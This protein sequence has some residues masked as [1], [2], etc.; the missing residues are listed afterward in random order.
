MSGVP[1]PFNGAFLDRPITPAANQ[2]KIDVQHLSGVWGE[3]TIATTARDYFSTDFLQNGIAELI[4]AG[5]NPGNDTY[6]VA[7]HADVDRVRFTSDGEGPFNI[8]FFS[9]QAHKDLAALLGFRSDGTTVLEAADQDA[10]GHYYTEGDFSPEGVW[11]PMAGMAS[12]EPVREAP[13]VVVR[14]ADGGT[15]VDGWPVELDRITAEFAPVAPERVR[16]D[17]YARAES[18][19]QFWSNLRGGGVFN[20][21]DHRVVA[22][23]SGL[24]VTAFDGVLMDVTGLPDPQARDSGLSGLWAS[25][26]SSG[27][28]EGVGYRGELNLSSA[29][30]LRES[31]LP[32][33]TGTM[34]APN[35]GT[36]IVSIRRP[37]LKLRATE[38]MASA[39]TSTRIGSAA[40]DWRSVTIEG[41]VEP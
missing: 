5:D 17:P 4:D 20:L 1:G 12:I 36:S 30:Q 27:A 7:Y 2:F 9:S 35:P 40:M 14:T 26:D 19:E 39:V 10:N 41:H 22:Q 6:N 32:G 33:S 34:T 3:H 28:S 38:R 23:L 11:N 8:R 15:V 37:V 13:A 31:P 29:T 21:H 24:A 25:I 16:Q 18:L